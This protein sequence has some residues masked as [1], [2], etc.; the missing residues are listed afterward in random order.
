MAKKVIRQYGIEIENFVDLYHI[1]SCRLD[2][3]IYYY[4][5]V[6]GI[7]KLIDSVE[8]SKLASDYLENSG[9]E[10]DWCDHHMNIMMKYAKTNRSSKSDRVKKSA[11]KLVSKK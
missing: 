6:E 11:G 10:L 8:L 3:N 1:V 2:Q 4:D 5:E 9:T 7:Y